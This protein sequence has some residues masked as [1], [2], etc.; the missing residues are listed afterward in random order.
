[1]GDLVDEAISDRNRI[2]RIV[3][4]AIVEVD[5][6]LPNSSGTGIVAIIVVDQ[7]SNIEGYPFDVVAFSVEDVAL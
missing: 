7:L 6:A 2:S 1:M 3:G 5:K 4:V